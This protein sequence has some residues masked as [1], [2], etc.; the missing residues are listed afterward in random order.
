MEGIYKIR[1][2]DIFDGNTTVVEIPDVAI[3]I[4]K[5]RRIWGIE[6]GLAKTFIETYEGDIETSII[7][8]TDYI[9]IYDRETVLELQGHR[10]IP[11]NCVIMKSTEKGLKGISEDEIE[12]VRIAYRDRTA[13]Y[14]V[15]PITILAYKLS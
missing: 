10:F 5:N 4:D 11:Y 15:G 9:I 14:Q 3:V 13:N 1:G 6:E 12:D 8:G 7:S 2:G